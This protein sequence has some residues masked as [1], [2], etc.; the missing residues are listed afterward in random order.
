MRLT[1]AH[2]ALAAIIA[3][4]VIGGIVMAAWPRPSTDIQV[5]QTDTSPAQAT[6]AN[7]APH[8]SAPA[9]PPANTPALAA[10]PSAP[11]PAAAA[12]Q[13]APTPPVVGVYITGEIAAPGVY[14]INEGSRLANL[15]LIA[16]GPTADADITAINL[17]AILRDEQHW[18]IPA[19]SPDAA[20][21]PAGLVASGKAAPGS[22][23]SSPAGKLNLNTAGV[24]QLKTLPGIGEVRAQAIV[25]HR[26]DNGSFT[27]VDALLNVN[28]IGIA[29]LE[30]IRGFIEV[31]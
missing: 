5:V 30:S 24:E 27:S 4:G 31:R 3:V 13:S 29:T 1:P 8:A 16:G 17:A 19:R 7:A 12:P 10:P 18:H 2:F 6:S 22:A 20:P 28:G 21:L 9:L 14:I 25:S 26:E 15:I 23:A 11:A